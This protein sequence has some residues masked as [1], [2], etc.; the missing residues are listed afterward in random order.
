MHIR[1]NTVRAKGKTYRYTQL[2]QSYRNDNGTP[3]T[4][5]LASFRDLPEV[6]V[7]NLR[8]ALSAARDGQSVVI[9]ESL[10]RQIRVPKCSHNLQ[11]LDIAVLRL[12]WRQLGLDDL[13]RSLLPSSNTDIAPKN[14]VEALVLQRCV[15]PD[16]K[17]AVERWYPSTALPELQSTVA[18][19]MNNTRLHR[20]LSDL[21]SVEQD[22]QDKLPAL[23]EAQQGGF[24][25]LAL[26]LTNTWFVGQ[27]PPMAKKART[28]EGLLRRRI[29]IALMCDHR[30]LPL[31]WKTLQGH[32]HE[33]TEM[34]AMLKATRALDWVGERPVLVDRAMGFAQTVEWMI[35]EDIR[36]LTAVRVSEFGSYTDRIP[37]QSFDALKVA[38]TE[39]SADSDIERICRVARSCGLRRVDDDCY[40]LDLGVI[41]KVA[42]RR[43]TSSAAPAASRAAQALEKAIAMKAA[44]DRGV[45]QADVGKEHGV[46]RTQVKNMLRLA[47]LRPELQR[48][49]LAGEADAVMVNAL[50][51][52][53]KMPEQEQMAAFEALVARAGDKALN[54]SRARTDDPEVSRALRA[55]I[56]FN[57]VRFLEQRRNEIGRLG[58]VEAF[59]DDLNRRLRATGSRREEMSIRSEVDRKLRNFNLH[60]VFDV[61]V[62]QDVA[63]G[64]SHQV[65]LKRN[66][67]AW[68]RQRRYDGFHLFVA[69][70]K[71]DKTAAE[72]V[73]LYYA[74]NAVE[75]DFQTIKSVLGLRPVR[76]RQDPKVRAHVTLCVLSLLLERCLEIALRHHDLGA[77][78]PMALEVL[79]HCHLNRFL[80]GNE[81]VYSV[82]EPE[83][84]AVEILR[85]LGATDL[86]DD[87]VLTLSIKPR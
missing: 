51:K 72:L 41:K 79:R 46:C 43:Y 10:A 48:R 26:D 5:I 57:P 83:E 65:E 8:L 15:A 80:L 84:A 45:K 86:V 56:V 14:V 33:A 12:L 2:V 23:L 21:E 50:T 40:V 27:G 52:V 81:P 67:D 75:R 85:A 58:E 32:Y 13:M 76:H 37:W 77:S 34:T 22:L 4:K 29:G 74:K 78:A 63:L 1:V 36:F 59:I 49:V 11:Y 3:A 47:S 44:R 39:T 54:A 17:L 60:S 6:M 28:K 35:D 82:T 70:P 38:G 73:A 16:S 31:R 71:L 55:V 69:H 87:E 30:G 68:Q 53:A 66:D 19:Q 61:A 62:V 18:A 24:V 20:T 9:A 7:E 64:G 25:W 42:P